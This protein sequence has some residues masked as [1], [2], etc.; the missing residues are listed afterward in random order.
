MI[1]DKDE[2]IDENRQSRVSDN[3][4]LKETINR[5]NYLKWNCPLTNNRYKRYKRR[6]IMR[7]PVS[8]S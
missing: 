7:K 3:D 5:V 4:E 8:G 1:E 6:A 2:F